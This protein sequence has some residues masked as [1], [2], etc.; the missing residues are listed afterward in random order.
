MAYNIEINVPTGPFFC[1]PTI[2]LKQSE[3]LFFLKFIFI[4]NCKLESQKCFLAFV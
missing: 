1:W 3:L 2:D 4:N